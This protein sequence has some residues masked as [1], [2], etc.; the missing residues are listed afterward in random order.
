MLDLQKYLLLHFTLKLDCVCLPVTAPESRGDRFPAAAAA[1]RPDRV[2]H[3]E[4]VH[5]GALLTYTP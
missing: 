2:I 3:V 1:D 4:D 5:I